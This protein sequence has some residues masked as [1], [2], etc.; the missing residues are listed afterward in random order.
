MTPADPPSVPPVERRHYP[1]RWRRARRALY[2][3]LGLIVLGA[4]AFVGL[5]KVEPPQLDLV[6]PTHARVGEVVILSGSGFSLRPERNA[7]YVGDFAARVLEA[8]RTRLLVEVPDMSLDPGERKKAP[9][10]VA[11]G[12][13]QTRSQDLTVEASLEPEPGADTPEDDDDVAPTPRPR[14]PPRSPIS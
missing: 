10:R 1:R 3:L 14:V 4:I 9:V 8:N 7:V 11:V 6:M 12:S 2:G 13:T 5:K